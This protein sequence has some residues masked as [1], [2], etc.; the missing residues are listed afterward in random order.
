VQ[1]KVMLPKNIVLLSLMESTKLATKYT[2]NQFPLPQ[3]GEEEEDEDEQQIIQVGT[4]FAVCSAGT[5]A[6]AEQKGLE[7]FDDCPASIPPQHE[8]LVHTL[9]QARKAQPISLFYGDRVQVVSY[10]GE[11]AK[12]ARG[13]GYVKASRDQLVKGKSLSDHQ[14]VVYR[15]LGHPCSLVCNPF[16]SR[17]SR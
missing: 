12:L 16:Y 6:V 2:R 11:W 3:E 1:E 8:V 5:Y 9:N 15:T 7:V 17:G 4:S 13:Q 14:S 10:N